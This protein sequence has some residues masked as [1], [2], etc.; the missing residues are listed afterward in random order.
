[1]NA[2]GENEVEGALNKQSEQMATTTIVSDD[3]EEKSC[4]TMCKEIS[5]YAVKFR[6]LKGASV[7]NLI[8]FAM[9]MLC[10]ISI[11]AK[12]SYSRYM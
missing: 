9:N 7:L 1:M 12:M 11:I 2:A 8:D 4:G 5:C 6:C 3:E 10:F